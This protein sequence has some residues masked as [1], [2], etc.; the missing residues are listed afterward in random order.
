MHFLRAKF[1]IRTK[2]FLKLAVVV[3][4]IIIIF[5]S[6]KIA[7]A[8]FLFNIL[9]A[10]FT[11]NVLEASPFTLTINISTAQTSGKG[12]ISKELDKYLKLRGFSKTI[13]TYA[14]NISKSLKDGIEL[15]INRHI[16]PSNLQKSIDIFMNVLNSDPKNGIAYHMLSASYYWIGTYE[17]EPANQLKAYQKGREYAE[18]LTEI[19]PENEWAHFWLF[20]NLGML[21]KINGVLKS[22]PHLPLLKRE[23]EKCIELNPN[24]SEGYSAQGMMFHELPAYLGGGYEK[25]V[26][27][28]KKSIDVDPTY[29]RAYLELS[30]TYIALKNFN[31][32]KKCLIKIINF[33]EPKYPADFFTY[34]LPQAKNLLKSIK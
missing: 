32:A 10:N 1:N 27:S 24:S 13:D 22:L 29:T 34:D 14:P 31:E 17:A 11:N 21:G 30:K 8:T 16:L 2:D 26:K 15:F 9:F 20:T 25:A 19:E 6:S 33:K 12:E 4:L 7:L 23:I 3:I 5:F 18:K 28:F